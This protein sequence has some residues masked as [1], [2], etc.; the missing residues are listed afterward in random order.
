LIGACIDVKN[1]P[2]VADFREARQQMLKDG[3]FVADYFWYAK[4]GLWLASWFVG[5]IGLSL[6]YI[7][8]GTTTMRMIGA[9][10][11]GIFGSS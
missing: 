4:L 8:N 3:L 2:H 9:L 10:M 11:M 1:Y 5:A 7:G 6:G